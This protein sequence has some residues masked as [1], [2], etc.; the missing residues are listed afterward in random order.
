MK[1]I[2][3][4]VSGKNA[5]IVIA[6]ISDW[7][8]IQ[9]WFSTGPFYE[10]LSIDDIVEYYNEFESG[11]AHVV[12]IEFQKGKMYPVSLLSWKPAKENEHPLVFE[13]ISKVAYISDSITI[14]SYRKRGLQSLLLYNALE[15]MKEKGFEEVY[16]RTIED[17]EMNSLSKKS[18]MEIC[19]KNG[20]TIIQ[21]TKTPRSEEYIDELDT[22]GKKALF[23]LLK[24]LIE[25]YDTDKVDFNLIS[26]KS[27]IMKLLNILNELEIQSED[28][29]FQKK[30]GK[31]ISETVDQV[32]IPEKRL[33]YKGN[34][35]FML[36]K[37]KTVISSYDEKAKKKYVK[38]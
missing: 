29:T 10:V 2:G 22:Y 31:N 37:L 35:D 20:N 33:F 26:N 19:K 34:I 28:K 32:S 11:G 9:E 4:K 8:P 38:Q 14:P 30:F 24:E 7:V 6:N 15:E 25:K 27:G 13:D 5:Y 21:I 1:K 18:G 16:L 3:R 23:D 17:S 36:N 12:K